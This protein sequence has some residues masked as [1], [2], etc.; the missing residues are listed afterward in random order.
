M[1]CW[2]GACLAVGSQAVEAWVHWEG[3]DLQL[4]HLATRRGLLQPWLL[5]RAHQLLLRRCFLWQQQQQGGRVLC[6]ACQHVPVACPNQTPQSARRPRHATRKGVFVRNYA[7]WPAAMVRG[8]PESE[9][10]VAKWLGTARR[11]RRNAPSERLSPV[12]SLFFDSGQ[13]ISCNLGRFFATGT[14]K[15]SCDALWCEDLNPVL[16]FQ[17]LYPLQAS[18]YLSLFIFIRSR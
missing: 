12:S 8:G 6:Y 1:S 13:P 16:L 5:Q 4:A 10:W 3:L 11:L 17:P 18:L 2:Q 9:V 15:A 7:P 14:G